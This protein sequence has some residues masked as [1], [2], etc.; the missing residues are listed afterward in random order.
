V[1]QFRRSF[2]RDDKA[3]CLAA[4]KF[5]AHL[6]NQQVAHEVLALELLTLLLEH[7]TDDSVE[8]AIAF[9]KECGQYLAGVS[10]RGLHEIF[11]RL[12][13]FVSA[14]GRR[15]PLTQTAA[16][17]CTRVRSTSACSI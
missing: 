10:P 12:R 14:V 3:S 7:P 4:G 11:E 8:V 9:V 15:K 1:I 13:R 6:V 17:F 16:V 2:R 5:I